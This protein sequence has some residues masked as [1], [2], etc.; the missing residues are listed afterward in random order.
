MSTKPREIA[1]AKSEKLSGL[2][3][4]RP[5]KIQRTQGIKET[6]A[7]SWNAIQVQNRGGLWEN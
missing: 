1:N 3:S 2:G 5:K 4:K 7:K 6:G